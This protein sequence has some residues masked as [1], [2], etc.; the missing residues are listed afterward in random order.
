MSFCAIW[1]S[2]AMFWQQV[3]VSTAP[4]ALSRW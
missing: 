2:V 1:C 3:E 4:V